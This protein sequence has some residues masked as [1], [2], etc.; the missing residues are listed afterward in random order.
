MKIK[1]KFIGGGLALALVPLV[2]SNSFTSYKA[3]SMAEEGLTEATE[4]L[5]VSQRQALASGVID[6]FEVIQGVLLTQASNP[7]VVS[8]MGDFKSAFSQLPSVTDSMKSEVKRYYNGQFAPKFANKNPSSTAPV[9]RMTSTLDDQSWYL[10]YQYI[11]NNPAELGAKD[12]MMTPQDSTEYAQFHAKY[13]PYMRSILQQFELYDIFLVDPNSGDVIYSV[14]KELNYT[15]SLKNGPYAQSGLGQAFKNAMALNQPGQAALTSFE[16]YLPSYNDPASFI[17]TPVFENGQKVGVLIFQMPLG[18]I[19]TMMTQNGQWADVGLGKTGEALL[20][21]EDGTLLNESRAI[22]ENTTDAIKAYADAGIVSQATL[23]RMKSNA[24]TVGSDMYKRLVQT[25]KEPQILHYVKNPAGVEVIRAIKPFSVMG[26]NWYL[27]TEMAESEAMVVASN[28]RTGLIS[29]ALIL[30]GVVA[31]LVFLGVRYFAGLSLMPLM[32]LTSRSEELASSHGADLTQKLQEDSA[33]EIAEASSSLNRFF[34][35]IRKVVAN[36]TEASRESEQATVHLGELSSAA[37]ND[38]ADQTERTSFVAAAT[39]EMS[40]SIHE[41]A[42]SVEQAAS[43][44]RRC[45]DLTQQTQVSFQQS[46]GR[47]QALDTEI[48]NSSAVVNQ[49]EDKT[50]E[51]GKVLDVIRD[52]ADQTNLLALNAAIEAARA[53]EQGRGF[54]VVADEVRKLASR[55]RE[56]TTEVDTIIAELQGESSKAV[57]RMSSSSNL[58]KETIEVFQSADQLISELTHNISTISGELE[59]VAAAAEEQ[60]TVASDIAMNLEVLNSISEMVNIKFNDMSAAVHQLN[61]K[62]KEMQTTVGVFK[63]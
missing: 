54:A 6:Y 39:T 47:L 40:A 8:A 43:N 26:Q 46:I 55:T 56:S 45:D 20:L 17:S 63:V 21:G 36:V 35:R 52:I 7:T 31:A 50:A 62:S 30:T 41:I 10:Q 29:F 57:Q 15:T 12:E 44:V 34:E 18:R 24:S 32:K 42:G 61:A 49:L 9:P 22:V 19:N 28:L 3:G 4:Q 53:G 23:N 25:V 27:L 51:I 2:L 38:V 60:N 59:Q 37:M 13:H 1:T 11:A 5:L 48:N 33:D 58:A 16:S 14:F